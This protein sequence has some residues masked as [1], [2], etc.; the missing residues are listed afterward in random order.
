MSQP[1][2]PIAWPGANLLLAQQLF[3]VQT[4][5]GVAHAGSPLGETLMNGCSST[6]SLT[7]GGETTCRL[8]FSA[9][10]GT[11]T[12]RL[13][14]TTEDLS[15]SYEAALEVAPCSDC[16]GDGRCLAGAQ[17]TCP[18]DAE[19]PTTCAEQC[20]VFYRCAASECLGEPLCPYFD[21]GALDPFLEHCATL[22]EEDCD[23]TIPPDPENCVLT[24][25]TDPEYCDGPDL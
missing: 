24:L 17:C 11:T 23:F 6:A 21:P 9:P 20:A 19:S 2:A 12:E 7:D 5:N 25:T 8:A 18:I 15:A 13:V 22:E 10:S 16:R 1:P 14:Y 3:A 4:A